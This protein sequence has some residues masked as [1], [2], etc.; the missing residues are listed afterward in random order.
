MILLP[1]VNKE[2]EQNEKNKFKHNPPLAF[3][4]ITYNIFNLNHENT[5][6]IYDAVYYI[7]YTKI[8]KLF[9]NLT[10]THTHL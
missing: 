3:S 8:I 7:Y 2:V 4:I 1:E 10:P 5:T 6:R 9:N